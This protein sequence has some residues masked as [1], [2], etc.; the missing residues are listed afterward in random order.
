M[1]LT[2]KDEFLY[3]AC[4]GIIDMF[5]YIFQITVQDTAQMIECVRADAFVF[6][7]A[8]QLAGADIILVDELILGYS[9]L[10]HRIP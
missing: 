2:V 9:P 1:A 8:V 6:S 7:K 10:L 5:S 4:S 3:Y